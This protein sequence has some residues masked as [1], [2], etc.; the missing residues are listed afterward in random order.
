MSLLYRVDSSDVD[1][2]IFGSDESVICSQ[3]CR[4][5]TKVTP[6]GVGFLFSDK[7]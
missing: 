4:E 5:A 1:E 6:A 7:F 2:L 3:R